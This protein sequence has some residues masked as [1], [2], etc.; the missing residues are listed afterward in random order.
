MLDIRISQAQVVNEGTISTQDVGIKDGRIH[1]IGSDLSH[2]DAREVIDAAGRH[3]LPG[4]IDD[5][6]H[7]REPGL[8]AKGN[9]A[10]ESAAAVAGGITTFFDM[11]NVKPA[12]LDSDALE[13]KFAVAA[14]RAHANHA[15]Y[16]G[17]SNDNLEAIKTLDPNQT[18]GIKIF[19]GA[20]TGNMLVDDPEILEGIFKHAPTPIVT[21]C[22]DTPMI[23][24]NEA[25][26]RERFGEDVP[27]SEHGLIRSREA[28]IKSSRLA[29]DLATRNGTQLHVLHLT[30]AEEMALFKAGPMKG[31]QITAE[32]C[33]HHLWFSDADYDTRGSLIKCNPAVKTA[34]DRAALRA[35]VMDGRIDIIATDHAPHTWEEKQNPYFK[36][37]SGLPLVQHALLSLL[38]QVQDGI[39]DL[40]TL[41]QKTSHNVADR[42]SI[43]DRGYI[44]EGAFADLVLVD[45]NGETSVTRDNVLYKCGW[46][47]FDGV[48]FKARIDAT[49][50][51]GVKAYDGKTVNPVANGQRLSFN[52]G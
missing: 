7:F 43:V 39:Y 41:V 12:T 17:A 28:C 31:K 18:C 2:L 49:F 33:A 48:T 5:Q 6:V 35:A 19:M 24:E 13:A 36:A 52:R 22:E 15:F 40:A 14:G 23:L 1:A 9:I 16:L 29:I 21:H 20:S 3:L 42:F 50:V 51:N 44:R 25:R 37:P 47:P 4:M 10:T 32:V 30:T 34:E 45:L 46:S 11:P 8:T 38:D 26:W 27:F